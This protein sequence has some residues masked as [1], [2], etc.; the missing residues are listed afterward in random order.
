[1]KRLIAVFLTLSFALA[2][3]LNLTDAPEDWSWHSYI[4][5]VTQN[6]EPFPTADLTLDL[7]S[8]GNFSFL[9]KAGALFEWAGDLI[10]YPFEVVR[11]VVHNF[12]VILD[13]F[14]PFSI[15]SSRKPGSQIGEAGGGGLFG[16]FGGGGFGGGGGGAR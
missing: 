7:P 11:T 5:F 9:E 1:M 10:L 14:L 12:A 8:D 16:E 4:E 2:L 13:G 15:T 3:F 6:I